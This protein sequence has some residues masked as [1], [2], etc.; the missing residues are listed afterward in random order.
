MLPGCREN[1][2]PGRSIRHMADLGDVRWPPDL[3]QTKRLILRRTE[4]R[5]RDGYIELLCSDEVRRYLGGPHAHEDVERAIPEVPGNHSGV[6]A[7]E[8]CG[9]FI[10]T[11]TLD[12][13][14]PTALVTFEHQAT[15]S[16]SATHFYPL[17]GETA[18][19]LRPSPQSSSGSSMPCPRSPSCSARNRPMMAPCVW[20]RAW[21]SWRRNGSSS[22]TPNSGSESECPRPTCGDRQG[23]RHRSV[24][25][26]RSRAGRICILVTRPHI[27]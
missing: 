1:V 8:A 2:P 10:G 18:T 19:P 20:Q 7:V 17:T 4:A 5:D 12:A 26:E 21:A 9:K 14:T 15:R 6:F 22:S 13:G 24:I 25:D 11:V 27:G 3:I 23:V 16:K